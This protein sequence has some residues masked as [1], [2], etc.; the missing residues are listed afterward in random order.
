VLS[1][2]DWES[3]PALLSGG[4]S[5]NPE[6]SPAVTRG[7]LDVGTRSSAPS[8]TEVC[9][10]ETRASRSTLEVVGTGGVA[11]KDAKCP[12]RTRGRG[13]GH[14]QRKCGKEHLF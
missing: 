4:K 3:L 1:P 6:R 14:Q 11:G 9:L 7:P 8:P 5:A 2:E 12:I 10:G 13:G